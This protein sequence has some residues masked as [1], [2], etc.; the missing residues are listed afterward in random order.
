M[1]QAVTTSLCQWRRVFALP[2]NYAGCPTGGYSSCRVVLRPIPY[3]LWTAPN[4][5]PDLARTAP[6][7]SLTPAQT[8]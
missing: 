3:P 4:V 2:W 8:S 1:P 6:H 7:T 5:V